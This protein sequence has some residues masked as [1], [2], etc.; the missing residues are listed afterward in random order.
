MT[1]IP[2]PASVQAAQQA[3]VASE[4]AFSVAA[5]QQ[6][7]LEARGEAVVELLEASLTLS[8]AID[9]G[10]RLDAQA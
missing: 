9:R 2:G 8:R 4:I 1:T 6:D 3:A 7:A 10:Q 5:K